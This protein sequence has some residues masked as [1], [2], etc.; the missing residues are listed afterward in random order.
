[1]DSQLKHHSL[2]DKWNFFYHLP[3]DKNWDKNSYKVV[4][5]NIDSVEKLIAINEE[6]P[7]EIVQNCMLFVMKNGILPLWE[8]PQNRTGG[9]FSFKVFNIH[10]PL[11]W[12]HLLYLLCG[13][14]LMTDVKLYPLVNGISVS[15]KRTFCIIK[16]W[17]KD[18][19]VQDP[20]LI[21]NEIK[22]LRSQGCLFKKHEPEFTY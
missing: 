2:L 14:T 7:N 19:C 17:M 3:S 15:P 8:D 13:G 22:H 6:M 21:T 18:C 4:M 1:M 12:R 20:D 5:S 11:V 16:I 10:V 9:A